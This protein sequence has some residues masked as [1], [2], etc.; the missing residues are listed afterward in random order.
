[1]KKNKKTIKVAIASQKGGGGK[2]TLTMLLANRLYFGKKQK[3]LIVDCDIPQNTCWNI[4]KDELQKIKKIYDKTTN[5]VTLNPEEKSLAKFFRTSIAKHPN[6]KEEWAIIIPEIKKDPEDVLSTV[7]EQI[8]VYE[9]SLYDIILFDTVG[10][11]TSGGKLLKLMQHMDYI[12]VPIEAEESAMKPAISSLIAFK[13]LSSN[14]IV[15]GFFNKFKWEKEQL[16]GM[17]NVVSIAYQMQLPIML[18]PDNKAL[19]AEDKACFRSSLVKTSLF[20]AEYN[21]AYASSEG[22]NLINKMC[23]IILQK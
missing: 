5:N 13:N 17:T 15:N 1:M 11:I 8:E 20:P 2:S 16:K 12:F 21:K 6:V 7:A 14:I 9:N 10:S 22:Y 4:R 3:V 23:E 19:Y 18:G